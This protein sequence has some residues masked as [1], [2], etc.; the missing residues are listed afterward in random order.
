MIRIKIS[1]I[2]YPGLCALVDDE[3][4][5][6]V[7][8]FKWHV[9]VYNRSMYAYAKAIVGDKHYIDMHRLLMMPKSSQQV[10]HIDHNG[11]N[12]QKINLRVC[13]A[14]QNKRNTLIPLSNTSGFK[15]VH[16]R[17]GLLKPWRVKIEFNKKQIYGGYFSTKE[18][19]AIKYNQMAVKYF[20]EFAYLNSVA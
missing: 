3:D 19:A 1:S 5:G 12:N 10:D 16:Y 18:E 2:K 7:S 13:S 14:N 4:F 9:R 15:G 11:L 17:R 6:K 8:G 20:G